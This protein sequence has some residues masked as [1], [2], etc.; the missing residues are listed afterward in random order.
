MDPMASVSDIYCDQWF[1][2]TAQDYGGGGHVSV[3]CDRVE[4][5]LAYLWL[6]LAGGDLGRLVEER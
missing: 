1:L 6:Y 4:D 5:G 2:V 3:Q